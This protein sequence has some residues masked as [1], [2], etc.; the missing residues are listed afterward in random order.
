MQ[1]SLRTSLIMNIFIQKAPVWLKWLVVAVLLTAFAKP[2]T[3]NEVRSL[4]IHDAKKS[5][6]LLAP[7]AEDQGL[8]RKRAVSIDTAALPS[9]SALSPDKPAKKSAAVDTMLRLELFDNATML[10]HLQRSEAIRVGDKAGV[11]FF[12]SVPGV[13]NS[14]V[15]MVEMN[16]VLAA[17]V[18]ALS[19]Q[20]QIRWR[21]DSGHEL[22]EIDSRQFRDHDIPAYQ[23]M[24]KKETLRQQQEAA[25][26]KTSKAP[27]PA[28]AGNS[29]ANKNT[30]AQ[31]D[32]GLTVDVMVLYTPQALA[33]A[34]G[35]AGM[36]SRIA[37]A[38]TETNE[39]FE[40]SLVKQRL[41]MVHSAAVSFNDSGN[42]SGDLDKLRSTSDG[43]MDD[44][45]ALRDA[46][47]ADVVSL[48]VANAGNLCG[49]GYL[50][51][52]EASNFAVSAFNVV[53]LGCA[54]GN[55]T[56][57]HELGHNMGLRH[58]VFVDQGTNT[59]TPEGSTVVS[60]G[61]RYAHGYIDTVNRFRTVMAYTD[62]CTAASVSC[63]KIK[64]FSNP[65]V[66]SNG[67]V[68]GVAT[69]AN[70]AR[71]LNDTRE[72]VANF[73]Q[74][75]TSPGGG[76]IS[77]LPTQ[78]TVAEGGT[79]TLS[80]Q[81][82][83]G[84]I[85]AASVAWSIQPGA[86]TRVAT[87]GQ[88]FTVAS[89]ELRWADGEAGSK[90]ISIT[91]LQ[92][93]LAEGD[94]TFNV[95]LANATGAVLS[96]ATAGVTLL[97]DEAGTF[98]VNCAMPTTGW[99]TPTGA[100]T[101][102]QIGTDS[103]SE[104]RCSLKSISPGD[105]PA[106]LYT[107]RSQL[108]YV[109]NFAAGN[110]TFDR[111]V[112]SELNWDCLRFYVDGIAQNVG[113]TCTG[114]GTAAGAG[115]SG[116]AAWSSITVPIT[117][118]RHT[119]M[120]SY[121]KDDSVAVGSDAAWIDKLVLPTAP[122]VP[123]ATLTVVRS[124]QGGGTVTSNIG[125][126]NCGSTCSAQITG[127]NS[128]T[129]TAV[130]VAGSVFTGWSNT[131]GITS[132]VGLAACTFTLTGATTITANFAQSTAGALAETSITLASSANPAA[133]GVAINLTASVT[134][135]SLTGAVS[136]VEITPTGATT[137]CSNVALTTTTQPRTA[138]C[139]VPAAQRTNGVH[140]YQAIYS[141]DASNA[142]SNT[143]LRQVVGNA[144]TQ[145]L[146][147]AGF[148]PVKPM[149]GQA[150]VLTAVVSG[151]PI[152]SQAPSGNLLFSGAAASCGLVA[153]S[154][155]PGTGK[156]SVAVCNLAVLPVGANAVSLSYLGDSGNSAS[157]TT[158]T[159]NVVAAG[160]LDYTSMWWAGEAENGW[161]MS[162]TQHG[163]VQFNALYVY[164]SAGKPM[165]YVMPGGTW[166]STFTT[167]SG[168]IYQPTGAPFSNY[169]TAQLNV[170]ASPGNVSIEFTS[171]N[172]AV[173]R[174]TINGVSGQKNITRQLLTTTT[175]AVPRLIVNDLWWGSDAENGWG[176]NIAQANRTLF[177][178]WYTYGADG[179][180]TWFVVPGG[181]WN[182]N[183]FTG[184]AFATTG[185]P[186]LGAAYDPT[187]LVV[188][189]VGSVSLEFLEANMAIMRYAVNG[190]VQAKVVYRQPY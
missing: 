69:T 79:L 112:S 80:V 181:T 104:G 6:L 135:S 16:G 78:Y 127:G 184:D 71:A 108:Q 107:R 18:R 58:D 140:I 161:G 164:D 74:A 165:W 64:N 116:E 117:A 129:L 23:Q 167:Y 55:L 12:G 150:V 148:S 28:R 70:N 38:T 121:E 176:L 171:V 40:N 175:E 172:N 102:W 126:I 186:W 17:N 41:R 130:A 36:Q 152:A 132:C 185:A 139:A 25:L 42:I 60:T 56:F 118:G 49:I 106:N 190:V 92:D 47:G 8:V 169:N 9:A 105:S 100:T 188:N 45:H 44:V 136:F 2:A 113:G 85:G 174:Y 77:F 14:S 149:T 20:Y 5:A 89:G 59:L 54:T 76:A 75:V 158:A 34:G 134:G 27:Q 3:A 50:M 29:S 156:T 101:G 166:N 153:L 103:A 144:V 31:A 114:P 86:G 122:D 178:V 173:L 109:G 137:M 15:T 30:T 93:T 155:L 162:I 13:P 52:V 67:A 94:E 26:L 125:G 168:A 87:P 97:D 147:S 43:V 189:R 11:A 65:D 119:L 1:S 142:A 63:P 179:R 157:N 143:T 124:G 62:G 83:G 10:V 170:G 22:R 95:Q 48:W 46:Y 4:F 180:A 131:Q 120:W 98:P 128:I 177:A 141:G 32:D 66:L 111:R 159:I 96:S 21:E 57:G 33:A 151:A 81:R 115:A 19:Q 72:T 61:V 163:T 82:I 88:D 187:K 123:E 90:S 110:I 51:S 99:S 145:T 146:L 24:A 35:V 37:L 91:L 138:R 53:A 39:S 154:P 73:R 133:V 183:I 84:S 68:T 182:G 7:S 160:P